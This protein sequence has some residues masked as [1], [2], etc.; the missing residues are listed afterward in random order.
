MLKGERGPLR[1]WRRQRPAAASALAAACLALAS[2]PAAAQQPA[3]PAPEGMVSIA[4]F[5]APESVLI[6]RPRGVIYVANINGAPGEAD[7]NGFISRIS[8]DDLSVETHWIDGADDDVRLDAPKGMALTPDGF[9]L[10]SDIDRLRAF[11]IETGEPAAMLEMADATFLN[12]L[13]FQDG[14]LYVSDSGG[15]DRP[16][17]VLAV[18]ADG[19]V[20]IVAEGADLARPNGVAVDGAGRLL[21]ATLD[22]ARILAIAEDGTI[23]VVAN[24]PAG[25]LDGLVALADGSL[26]VSSWEAGAIF[27]VTA[28]GQV[29]TLADGLASPADIDAEIGADS[30]SSL[31]AIPLLTEDRVIV[32][33]LP[34]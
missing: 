18:D 29:V 15:V 33:P 1:P 13:W 21:V 19:G 9:L 6:D 24:L 16:G 28:D 2:P 14:T 25:R 10:V 3:A 34:E 32:M 20:A 31:L 8:L 22:A 12:D 26:L 4:G 11:R 7:D 30:A 23:S 17:R 5:A 27:R